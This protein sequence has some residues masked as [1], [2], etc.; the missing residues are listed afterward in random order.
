VVKFDCRSQQATERFGG[1]VDRAGRCVDRRR[2]RSA[3][4]PCTI[5]SLDDGRPLAR[6][7]A[8]NTAGVLPT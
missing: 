3:A 6:V 7:S 8:S 2:I 4:P 5:M 1:V